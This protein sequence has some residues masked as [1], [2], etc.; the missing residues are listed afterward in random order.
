M[1]CVDIL[2]VLKI[3]R[4]IENDDIKYEIRNSK[5]PVIGMNIDIHL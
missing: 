3:M 1:S 5:F 2:L 4:S